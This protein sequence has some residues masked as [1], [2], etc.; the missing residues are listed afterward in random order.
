MNM[1]IFGTSKQLFA[2]TKTIKF[3]EKQRPETYTVEFVETKRVIV[4]QTFFFVG[5]R[6]QNQ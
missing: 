2:K 5:Q 1:M 3:Q 6:Y 4:V